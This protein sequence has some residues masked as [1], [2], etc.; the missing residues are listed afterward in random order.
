MCNGT[1]LTL[2]YCNFQIFPASCVRLDPSLVVRAQYGALRQIHCTATSMMNSKSSPTP[3]AIFHQLS[4]W[5]K[6]RGKL[7]FPCIFRRKGNKKQVNSRGVSFGIPKFGLNSI[8]QNA[9]RRRAYERA[10]ATK[11]AQHLTVSTLSSQLVSLLLV[12][13]RDLFSL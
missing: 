6:N 3:P 1:D 9:I 8:K 5:K 10:Q 11:S 7:C 4:K 13:P 12:A 2:E